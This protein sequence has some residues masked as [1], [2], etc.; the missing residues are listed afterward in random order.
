[1]D[2]FLTIMKRWEV[3]MKSINIKFLQFMDFKSKSLKC[4]LLDSIAKKNEFVKYD[5]KSTV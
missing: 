2:P 4:Q 3:F 5:S 1:M